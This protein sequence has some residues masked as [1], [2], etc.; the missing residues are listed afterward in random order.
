MGIRSK[1]LQWNEKPA[2]REELPPELRAEV[3]DLLRDDVRKLSRLIGRDLD[4]WLG[5][6]DQYGPGGP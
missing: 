1:L 3:R 2:K 6:A 5:G 4:Q